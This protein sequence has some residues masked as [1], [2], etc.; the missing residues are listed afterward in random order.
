MKTVVVTGVS[1]GIG[2]ATALALA[3]AG[4]KVFGS[5]RRA[6][7]AAARARS[8]PMTAAAGSISPIPTAICWRSSPG[9]TAAV[10]IRVTC[11]QLP[12]PCAP[13]FSSPFSP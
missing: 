4:F 6:E 13:P 5:V 3:R 1:S 9:R 12:A 10:D 11:A 2:A 7:D 8:T